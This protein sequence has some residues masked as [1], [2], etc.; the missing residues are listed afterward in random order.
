MEEIHWL[1]SYGGTQTHGDDVAESSGTFPLDHSDHHHRDLRSACAP[2][3]LPKKERQN[4]ELLFWQR[5]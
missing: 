5:S 3:L 2:A 4:A 1:L